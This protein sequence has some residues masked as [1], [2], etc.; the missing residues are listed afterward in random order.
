VSDATRFW[1]IYSHTY[2][3]V[4]FAIPY[5]QLLDALAEALALEDGMTVLDLG[6]ATGNVEER[7]AEDQAG[8][9]V[10]GVDY[11]ESMLR[12]ARRKCERFPKVGFVRAD[13]AEPL[14][15]PD[16]SFDRVLANNVLYALPG[17]SALLAEARR[18]LRPGGLLVLSDPKAGA[19]IRELVRAHF[20][21]IASMTPGRRLIALAKAFVTLPLMGLAP[22]MLIT[23]SVAAKTREGEY[24]FS[25]GAELVEL[26]S[27]FADV[28]VTEAYAGQNWLAVAHEPA[29]PSRR[30][31]SSAMSSDS[32]LPVNDITSS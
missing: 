10:T 9:C 13:L 16:A 32:S 5:G 1:D 30:T 27:D 23:S 7:L 24:R 28:R 19:S 31:A 14:P 3:A 25:T 17:R 21:A 29:V 2:D 11:S 20:A 26:L 4:R 6:C 15:F 22:I 8:I 12:R 18:V